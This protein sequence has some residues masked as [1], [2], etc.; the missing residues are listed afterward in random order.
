MVGEDEAMYGGLLVRRTRVMSLESRRALSCCRFSSR[1]SAVRDNRG[2]LDVKDRVPAGGV[3]LGSDSWPI[4]VRTA[5]L[6]L[7]DSRGPG[8]RGQFSFQALEVSK[9]AYQAR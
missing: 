9:S 1:C 6:E 5:L 7:W 2:G 3:R 4:E 8:R